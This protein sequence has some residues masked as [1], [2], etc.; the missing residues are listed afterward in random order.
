VGVGMGVPVGPA[1][2]VGD[3]GVNVGGSGELVGET[4]TSV[5][6][7]GVAEGGIGVSVPG[8]GAKLW[9]PDAGVTGCVAQA[10][11]KASVSRR[12][13]RAIFRASKLI[14]PNICFMISLP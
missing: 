11:L 4:R 13:I 10:T 2:S 3:T 8:L 6:R 1:V 7:T 9:G 12:A 5:G 14:L